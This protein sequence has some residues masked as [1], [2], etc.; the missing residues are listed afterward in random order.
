MYTVGRMAFDRNLGFIIALHHITS[1]SCLINNS[2]ALL[3]D[4]HLFL[5]GFYHNPG[6]NLEFLAPT[7]S[8]LTIIIHRCSIATVAPPFTHFI[9]QLTNLTVLADLA[10]ADRKSTRLNSSHMSIS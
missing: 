1:A 7:A 8:T 4:R 9:S 3:A 10:G 2:S 5:H 6:R